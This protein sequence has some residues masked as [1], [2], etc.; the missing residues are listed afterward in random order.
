MVDGTQNVSTKPSSFKN[1]IDVA[2]THLWKHQHDIFRSF[3]SINTEGFGW[4]CHDSSYYF[5]VKDCQHAKD[6]KEELISNSKNP[7]EL[8]SKSSPSKSLRWRPT[9]NFMFATRLRDTDIEKMHREVSLNADIM[10][11]H[12][13]KISLKLVAYANCILLSS[14][15]LRKMRH[16]TSDKKRGQ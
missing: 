15:S 4:K 8:N 7:Y 14:R 13:H 1:N 5:E 9:I 2:F 10:H 6:H 11:E 16:A 12:R 3:G